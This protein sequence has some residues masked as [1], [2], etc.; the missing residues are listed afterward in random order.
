MYKYSEIYPHKRGHIFNFLDLLGLQMLISIQAPNFN[1]Q[2]FTNEYANMHILIEP[3]R[4]RMQRAE[5]AF[6]RSRSNFLSS[7]GKQQVNTC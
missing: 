7:K 6:R 5:S 2:Q 1:K 4:P 3:N